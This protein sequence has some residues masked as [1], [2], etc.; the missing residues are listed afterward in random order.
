MP[1]AAQMIAYLFNYPSIATINRL[2]LEIFFHENHNFKV[3]KAEISC[4][5]LV[6]YKLCV[7]ETEDDLPI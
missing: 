2:L 4:I 3:I 7:P 5:V 1:A 6:I